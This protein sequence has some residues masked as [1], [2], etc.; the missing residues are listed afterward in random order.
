MTD[1]KDLIQLA[2]L[3]QMSFENEQSKLA[4]ICADEDG[5]KSRLQEL[6][7]KIANL[8]NNVPSQAGFDIAT[9]FGAHEK[10]LAW[11]QSQIKQERSVLAQIAQRKEIQKIKTKRAFGRRNALENLVNQANEN[12][13]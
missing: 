7:L 6:E 2:K 12:S 3:A 8:Q 11:A 10:W 5:P 1:A 4:S 9:R 13:K